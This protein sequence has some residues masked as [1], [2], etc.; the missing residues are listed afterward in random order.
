MRDVLLV[1]LF[2]YVKCYFAELTDLKRS[3]SRLAEAQLVC[4]CDDV[5]EDPEGADAVIPKFQTPRDPFQLPDIS[6][7]PSNKTDIIG[8]FT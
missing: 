3:F 6:E 5:L 7:V 8:L 4:R 1:L 2:S